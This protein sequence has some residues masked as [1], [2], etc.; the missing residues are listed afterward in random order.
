[1][2]DGNEWLMS[3]ELYFMMDGCYVMS[4]NGCVMGDE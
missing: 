4:Y 1:M 2:I 3:D